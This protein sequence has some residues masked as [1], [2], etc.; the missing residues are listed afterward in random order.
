MRFFFAILGVNERYPGCHANY[1]IVS[2]MGVLFACVCSMQTGLTWELVAG[3]GIGVGHCNRFFSDYFSRK[4]A[5]A[6][7]SGA[8]IKSSAATIH[9]VPLRFSQVSVQMNS[10][11][12]PVFSFQPSLPCAIAM[13]P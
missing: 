10:P 1:G 8:G 13:S 4:G 2:W 6:N 7:G 11:G 9:Q 3:S 12:L 5:F